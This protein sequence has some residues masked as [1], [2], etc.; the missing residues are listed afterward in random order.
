MNMG[1]GFFGKVLWINLTEESFEEHLIPEEI[2]RQYLGGYG[3]AIKLIYETM[4][5]KINPL[6]PES[7]F[8]F[9]PGF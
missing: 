4:P 7:I 1:T 8:G 3:L 6:D 9:F 5:A 2:Y